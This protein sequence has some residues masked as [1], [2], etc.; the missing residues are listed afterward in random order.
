M[1]IIKKVKRR[2]AEW[3]KIFDNYRSVKDLV[4]RICKY[5]IQFNNKKINIQ[6]G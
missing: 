5:V 6:N 2:L 4:S 3:E 1:N